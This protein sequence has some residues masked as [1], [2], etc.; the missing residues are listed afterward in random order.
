MSKMRIKSF[1]NNES[2]KTINNWLREYSV[3]VI[4]IKFIT[5]MH[6]DTLDSRPYAIVETKI[7][8]ED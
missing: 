4:D 7:I 5:F 6:Q 3:R 1:K 2:D 8:Y